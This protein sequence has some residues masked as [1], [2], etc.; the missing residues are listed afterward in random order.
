[1]AARSVSM[2]HVL[3]ARG[4]LAQ[5]GTHQPGIGVGGEQH[6][7]KAWVCPAQH[8]GHHNAVG[9]GPLRQVQIGHQHIERGVVRGGHRPGRLAE[10]PHNAHGVVGER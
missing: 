1:M 4:Y 8:V 6:H 10:V 3:G 2:S 7:A 9:S 5:L